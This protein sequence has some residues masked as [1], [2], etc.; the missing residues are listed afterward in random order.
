MPILGITGLNGT[1]HDSAACLIL[2]N[3]EW[4]A[5]EEERLNRIKH[6]SGFPALS[7]EWCLKET[8][9]NKSDI[10]SAGYF[11][12]MPAHYARYFLKNVYDNPDATDN[13]FYYS[14]KLFSYWRNQL[15]DD[16]CHWLTI[17]RSKL[18]PIRH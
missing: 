13:F 5:V 11:L 1:Y 14:Y 3:G 8:G 15:Y 4:V 17:D 2:D 10:D 16:I 9:I 7:I 6:S 12:N 18:I